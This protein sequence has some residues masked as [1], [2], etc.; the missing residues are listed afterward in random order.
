MAETASGG[1]LVEAL[2]F[3]HPQ[4]CVRLYGSLSLVFAKILLFRN[5]FGSPI[6]IMGEDKK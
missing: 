6:S 5:P 3:P 4:S 2:F 1:Y